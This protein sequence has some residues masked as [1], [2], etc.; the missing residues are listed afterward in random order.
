MAE[1]VDRPT[2]ETVL[3]EQ[4]PAAYRLAVGLCGSA[5]MAGEVARRVLNRAT[6]VALRWTAAGAD[7]RWFLRF[8]VLASRQVDRTD[9]GAAG[10]DWL[11]SLP[12][13]QR[14]AVVLAHGLQLDLHR[15]AAAMD[16]SSSAAANHLVAA[17]AL[18]QG[19]GPVHEWTAGLPAQLAA[20]VP[21]STV[22]AADVA[23]AVSRNRWRTWVR[24]GV[25]LLLAA[26]LLAVAWAGWQAWRMV[27]I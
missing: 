5:E 26:M 18:L 22:I 17:V 27:V 7:E 8:T 15:V 9:G 1:V 3:L 24:R 16:C 14:E 12:Q 25:A 6:L 20:I 19:V 11:T 13:Q 4:Y 10:L 21:P 2:L 23:H